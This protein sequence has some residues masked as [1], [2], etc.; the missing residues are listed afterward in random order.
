MIGIHTFKGLQEKFPQTFHPYNDKDKLCV[1]P[2]DD[3]DTC[4]SDMSI[5]VMNGAQFMNLRDVSHEPTETALKSVEKDQ[6]MDGDS[7]DDDYMGFDPKIILNL[8]RCWR[9]V[10]K[11]IQESRRIRETTH[12]QMLLF[13]QKLCSMQLDESSD[14][15]SLTKIRTRAFLFTEGT[16]I[17]IE[18]DKATRDIQGHRATWKAAIHHRTSIPDLERL[19]LIASDIGH[20]ESK[21]DSLRIKWSTKGF[22]KYGQ[23]VSPRTL[24]SEA[25]EASRALT[26]IRHEMDAIKQKLD[27]AE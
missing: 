23:L 1:I 24:T 3:K 13:I 10:S 4:P 14:L 5:L 8:Q 15:Q 7:E 12:G 27:F 19:D 6:N 17:L 2:L 22:E 18:T 11:R 20:I 9:H 16:R 21:L 25:R 26:S